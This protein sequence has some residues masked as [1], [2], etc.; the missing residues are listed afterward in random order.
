MFKFSE[1]SAM[2]KKFGIGLLEKLFHG[3][4]FP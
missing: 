1:C 4:E 2:F 3:K